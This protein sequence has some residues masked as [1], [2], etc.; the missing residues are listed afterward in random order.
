MAFLH[1]ATGLGLLMAAFVAGAASA[2]GPE[3]SIESGR[4]AGKLE[5]GVAAYRGIPYAAAPV[6]SLRWRAPQAVARWSG[7]RPAQAYGPACPQT[8]SRPGQIGEAPGMSEDCL[9]LNVWTSSADPDAKR[10]VIVWLHG[11]GFMVG[12][13]ATPIANG[14]AFARDGV[15]FVSINY[16]LARLGFFSHPAVLNEQRDQVV[17]NYGLMDQIAALQWVQ[18]NIRQFGG[19]PSNVTVA[20]QSAG[21]MA[22]NFMLQSP[23]SQGLASKA[24]VQSGFGTTRTET[25]TQGSA[26]DAAWAKE[27]GIVGSDAAALEKL[28]ALSPEAFLYPVRPGLRV[29]RI[30]DVLADSAVIDGRLLTETT[31]VAFEGGKIAPIPYMI[32]YTDAEFAANSTAAEEHLAEFGALGPEVRATYA[33]QG[34]DLHAQI[35]RFDVDYYMAEPAQML[36][37]AMT[38]RGAP[39]FAYRFDYVA[40]PLREKMVGAA[41]ASELPYLFGRLDARPAEAGA[42]TAEDKA[43][44]DL[45]RRYWVNFARTGDPNGPGAPVWPRYAEASD[46][47]LAFG[48]DGA[49]IKPAGASARFEL[50]RKVRSSLNL[51][52]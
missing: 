14:Q 13:S 5:Q 47:L 43:L 10:P 33:G 39:V 34:R 52:H 16:R 9:T 49:Q 4:V 18:R 21:G 30:E 48:A 46:A 8:L 20:G 36:A 40:T 11:G 2:G 35:T 23:L 6:G 42:A 51:A 12:S 3:V 25:L 29:S 24:I 28:R 1:F 37:R 17:A 7:V 41:H 38:T 31:P 27:Q 45:V 26:R 44:G 15:V 32:G 22:V 19:D 50:V